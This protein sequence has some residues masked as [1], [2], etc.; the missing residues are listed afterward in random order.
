[1]IHKVS[2]LNPGTEK[3]PGG[4]EAGWLEK[5]KHKEKK[6]LPWERQI[7]EVKKKKCKRQEKQQEKKKISRGHGEK[8]VNNN[9]NQLFELRKPVATPKEGSA[10]SLHECITMCFWK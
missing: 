3:F 4:K 8:K 10:V 6:I 2:K 9:K 7:T 1:M 5:I